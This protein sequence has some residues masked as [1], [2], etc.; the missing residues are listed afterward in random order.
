MANNPQGAGDGSR[1]LELVLMPLPIVDRERIQLT[2]LSL[3]TAA[4][5]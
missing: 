3:A 1:R 4:A 5:V 2:T